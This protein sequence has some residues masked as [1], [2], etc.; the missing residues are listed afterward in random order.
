MRLASG[1]RRFYIIG[2][3]VVWLCERIHVGAHVYEQLLCGGGGV[4]G[5]SGGGGVHD[6][7]HAKQGRVRVYMWG[8]LTRPLHVIY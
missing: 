7:F 6:T 1:L 2:G 3:A 8:L 5:G 4:V